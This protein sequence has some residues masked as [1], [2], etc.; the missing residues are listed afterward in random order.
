MCEKCSYDPENPDQQ[1]V[2]SVVLWHDESDQTMGVHS[3]MADNPAPIFREVP[4]DALISIERGLAQ[5]LEAIRDL[6]VRRVERDPEDGKALVRALIAETLG[7]AVA[8]AIDVRVIDLRRDFD[9][10]RN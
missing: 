4:I 2:F 9:P 8:E 7:L 5:T 1:I 3:E 6:L 10:N